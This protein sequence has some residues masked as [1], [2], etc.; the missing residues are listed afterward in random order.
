[1]L[2]GRYLDERDYAEGLLKTVKSIARLGGVVVV[3]RGVNFIVGPGVGVHLRIVAPLEERVRNL[4]QRGSLSAAE[5]A[6]EIKTVDQERAKFVRRLFH[7]SVDDP[8][9]Y[10]MIINESGHSLESLVAL[11]TMVVDEKLA[12]LGAGRPRSAGTPGP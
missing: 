5:A 12:R 4:M 9:A 10:D 8:V 6:H 3:G 2:S 1:M 7:R 11:T